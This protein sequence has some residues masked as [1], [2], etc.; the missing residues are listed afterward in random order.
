M[1]ALVML[2]PF[3]A[4]AANSRSQDHSM[5][6]VYSGYEFG[7][8]AKVIDFAVQPL[9]VPIGVTA[10]VM[11]RDT[12]LRKALGEL[13]ME[14]RFHPFMKG[15]DI[16][17]FLKQ[18]DIEAATA[19][20]M[21]VITAAAETDITVT[22]LAKRGFSSIISKGHLQLS[23]LKGL[24]VG[25]PEGSTAHYTLLI[26]LSQ[27][28]MSDADIIM[29]PLNVDKLIS[30]L[31]NGKIDAFSAYEPV[32][33]IALAGNKDFT[34]IMKYLNTTYL[35]FSKPF[36]DNYREAASAIL[37]SHVRA[38]RWM[39]RDKRNL[40]KAC[41]WNIDA[42]KELSGKGMDLSVD[43]LAEIVRS[44]ILNISSSPSIPQRDLADSGYVQRVFNMLKKH[45]KVHPS[46][47]LEKVISS[48][49]NSMIKE[50]LIHPVKFRL[51][52][53]DYK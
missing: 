1:V 8:D 36:I 52:D 7:K 48:F 14:I 31:E 30:E 13:G 6:P 3:S 15:A 50:V 43:K 17:F 21:P 41:G 4:E 29:V 23:E 47:K 9:A 37:A 24:R 49:D 10:E 2:L 45:Q 38:L 39:I 18:G 5:H 51:N 11:K 20:D 33:A 12:I 44:D 53:F 27:Y 22:A 40:L 26:A 46:A 25:F 28:G 16:N 32:P 34:V 19:G 42:V 35:Y